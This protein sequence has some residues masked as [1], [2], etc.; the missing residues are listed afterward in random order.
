M[1]TTGTTWLI[2]A[3][4]ERLD[5]SGVFGAA[6]PV[7]LD[8]G[9]GMGES[10][11]VQ[12]AKA[13]EM[14]VIAID[15]HTRGVATLMRKGERDGLTNVRVVHGDAVTFI[16]ERLS[17]A[18]IVGARIYFPDPWPKVR[19]RKRRLVQPW[20]VSLLVDRIAPG[21]F[22]HCATDDAAYAEQMLETLAAHP[23]LHNP[24]D[25]FAPRSIPGAVDR[26]ST[27][28]E[29]RGEQLGHLVRDVWVTRRLPA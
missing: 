12:A 24:F 6:M 15:V 26:P 27:K 1:A 11:L 18:A 20:F 23:R 28:Y 25:G 10:T 4:G 9:C 19:H 3:S 7:V 14:G 22:V 17:P 2:D 13:P 8:I 29:R 5:V 21:G 16:E